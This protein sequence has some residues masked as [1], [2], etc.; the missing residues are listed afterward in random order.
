V[1]ER[2]LDEG[3]VANDV[4]GPRALVGRD[5]EQRIHD[6]VRE[7]RGVFTA[8]EADDPRVIVKL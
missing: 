5:G 1:K 8:G 2:R 6:E 7:Q 4:D 3:V